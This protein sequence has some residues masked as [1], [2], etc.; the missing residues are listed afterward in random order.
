[1]TRAA[2]L[3][4]LTIYAHEL[5]ATDEEAALLLQSLIANAPRTERKSARVKTQRVYASKNGAPL[6]VREDLIKGAMKR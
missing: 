4:R 6:D 2:A 1:M 3:D 5:R